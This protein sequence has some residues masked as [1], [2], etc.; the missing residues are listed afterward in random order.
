[1]VTRSTSESRWTARHHSVRTLLM[2]LLKTTEERLLP[3][4]FRFLFSRSVS[5]SRNRLKRRNMFLI[6]LFQVIT[7]RRLRTVCMK[8]R[9]QQRSLVFQ[10]L[11][12]SRSAITEGWSQWPTL[13]ISLTM[14][15]ILLSNSCHLKRTRP[16]TSATHCWSTHRTTF[17]FSFTPRS[18]LSYL[19]AYLQMSSTL[20]C[21]K[22]CLWSRTRLASLKTGLKATMLSKVL[23][24]N[25]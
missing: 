15:S 20:Q 23:T 6:S 12:T 9:C 1:M 18:P 25:F 10:R 5:S 13:R 24:F 11:A 3:R 19:R 2:S 14:N 4:L 17:S 22:T 16:R 7:K 21:A 8:S